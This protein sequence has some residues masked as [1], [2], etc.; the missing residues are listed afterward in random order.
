[1]HAVHV[2]QDEE[3]YT[4]ILSSD[5]DEAPHSILSSR[6]KGGM[7]N[8]EEDG[9]SDKVK[10]SWRKLWI[11]TGPGFLMS[12]AYLDPGNIEA[13]LQVGVVAGYSLLWVLLW[14]TAVGW[15]LQQQA[16]VLGLS[17]GKDL[18]QMCRQEYP[19]W[20]RIV[21]FTMTELVIIGSDLQEV[22]GSAIAL[23]ILS[24]G[25]IPL[26]G[27]VLITVADTFTFLFLEKYG[28]GRLEALFGVLI[29]TMAIMF[30]VEMVIAQPNGYS[31][32]KGTVVPTLPS[33]TTTVAVAMIGAIIMP[34]NIYLHSAL[35]QSRGINPNKRK[36]VKEGI[37]YHSLEAAIA[38]GVSFF[39]NLFVVS[40]FAEGF[41][42]QF[43]DVSDIGLENAGYF[44]EQ[45]YGE[46][47]LYIWAVG[48]LAAGQS[49]TM[50]GT[51][52]GQF[53][54]KGF[55]HLKMKKWQQVLLT[56][57]LAICPALLVCFLAPPC[58]YRTGC[59]I[60]D[61]DSVGGAS[62]SLDTL[63]E[64]INV[65]Q[66]IQLP[67]AL[68][69][70]ITFVGDVS[71]CSVHANGRVKSVVVWVAALGLVVVNAYQVITIFVNLDSWY[72]IGPLIPVVI[73]YTLF[74]LYLIIGPSKKNFQMLKRVVFGD[75]ERA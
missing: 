45:R 49:S 2:L 61:S 4:E 13:D 11:Y 43:D 58:D 51:Y 9:E 42:G 17:T 44:L 18:S 1:M 14:S 16:I 72:I 47:A 40:V 37:F 55:W 71:L 69:P 65:M 57:S 73:C 38:L 27:G 21:L 8:D 75:V 19:L 32:L 50:T 29:S 54:M 36:E 10:F 31:I 62:N 3:A 67:F 68:F 52:A 30:G 15:L 28:V 46:A 48:I 20:A 56:R 6:V 63:N 23:N 22:V 5:E 60:S 24:L 12:V 66:S 70:V 33:G 35:V 53:V 39:I 7:I 25:T 34:H 59:G 41:Y 74:V 26:W 64:Y